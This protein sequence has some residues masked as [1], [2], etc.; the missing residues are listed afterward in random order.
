MVNTKGLRHP[1]TIST[2]VEDEV[3]QQFADGLP[4][5]K[6]VAEAIREYMSS[7]VEEQK[8]VRVQE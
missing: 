3:Y 7:V 1:R 6:T 4:R 2:V 8:K 5:H